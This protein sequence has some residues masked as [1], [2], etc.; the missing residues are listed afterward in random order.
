MQ[1]QIICAMTTV[2]EGK[3]LCFRVEQGHFFDL[4]EKDGN[5]RMKREYL[6]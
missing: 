3:C 2:V 4:P 5:K 6:P 1:L